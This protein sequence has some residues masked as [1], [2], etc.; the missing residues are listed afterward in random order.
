MSDL[1]IKKHRALL[2]W[3]RR[4]TI[5]SGDKA[6][7]SRSS[8]WTIIVVSYYYTPW[9][10]KLSY[11]ISLTFSQ[12]SNVKIFVPFQEIKTSR[13]KLKSILNR[14]VLKPFLAPTIF[15]SEEEKGTLSTNH[16]LTLSGLVEF[17]NKHKFVWFT[18]CLFWTSRICEDS[19]R[20]R[21]REHER[22]PVVCLWE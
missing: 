19:E 13:K 4:L 3:L 7:S 2:S 18:K 5:T 17:L 10:N 14:K 20:E 21:E 16:L 15:S 1:L 6:S 8:A 12:K 9:Q 22:L 11:F